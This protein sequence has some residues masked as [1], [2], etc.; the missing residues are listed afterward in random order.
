MIRVW[1]VDDEQ[2]ALQRLSRMLL[3]TGR[4]RIEGMSGDPI[5]AVGCL[6][7]TAV[8]AIFLDI[9]MPGCNGFELLRLLDEA[10]AG[11]IRPAVV[12]TTAYDRYAVRAFEANGTDYLLKPVTAEALERA[13]AK[14]EKNR[15]ADKED[16]HSMLARLNGALAQVGRQYP[17][18]IPS[19]LGDRVQFV[20][21]DKVTHFF[22]EG[23]LTYAATPGKN[24][25]VD[26]SI[27]QLEARLDPAQFV[28]IHRGYL[29]NLAAVAEVVS[30]FHGKMVARLNDA[31]K[32]E[33]PIARDRLRNLKERLGF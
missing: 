10:S 24:F 21:L 22:A 16:F 30:W 31:A 8:D 32:T 11:D 15:P 28:R 20:D 2:L 12:F 19:K 6:R 25:V 17:R 9:E 23:K 14:L 4:V 7:E 1:L 33:L 27:V 26:E 13:L 5:E 18:R 29:V 3:E